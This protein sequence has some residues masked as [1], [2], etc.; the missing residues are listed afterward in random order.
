M[1]LPPPGLDARLQ[2]V[3]RR[4]H[5]PHADIG[6]NHAALPIFLVSSGRLPGCVATELGGGP[7]EL[8]WRT[9]AR[10]GLTGRID[11]R[12]GSGF[13]PLRPAEVRSASVCGMG[14]RLILEL[15]QQAPWLPPELILQPNRDTALLRRWA[16][17]HG[18]HLVHEELVP[19]HWNYPVLHLMEVSGLDPA[20][21]DL[22]L[23]AAWYAG[24]L[25]LRRTDPLLADELR[26]QAARLGPLRAPG[27]ARVE[28]EWKLLGEAQRCLQRFTR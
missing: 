12:Q 1:I 25:L 21:R 10:A 22:P 5:G 13:A 26:H 11:L 6:T 24:P 2:A 18:Y 28:R 27:R 9:V 23:E 16:W 8:A 4:A 7:L 19:G 15:L 3:A 17:N 20:Y 14:G